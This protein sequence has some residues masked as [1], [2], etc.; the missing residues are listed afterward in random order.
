MNIASYRNQDTKAWPGKIALVVI[1]GKASCTMR[2][3]EQEL[4][5]SFTTNA[6]IFEGDVET[7]NDLPIVAKKMKLKNKLVRVNTR[8]TNPEMIKTMMKR[9]VVDF[10][11]VRIPA[12]LY[13]EAFDKVGA[14]GFEQVRDTV[15]LVE[16]S[17][18]PHEIV[19]EWSNALTPDDIKD[20]ASQVR[21][22]F[23]L[24]ADLPFDKLRALAAGL[25]G[26][27]SVRIR[28]KNREQSI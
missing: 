17:A 21:G 12:P 15:R 18:T 23:V 28:D 22:T 6:V 27:K 7:Q 26:P 4:Q 13:K 10:V 5:K 14:Q 16:S 2:E 19:L 8:G 24:Y 25:S 11:S 20:A 3:L 9:R 1:A